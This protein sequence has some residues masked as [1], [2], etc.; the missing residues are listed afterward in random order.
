MF[1]SFCSRE[2]GKEILQKTFSL[3]GHTS[4]QYKIQAE[5]SSG[6]CKEIACTEVRHSQVQTVV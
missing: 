4:L 1:E 3:G 2:R 5:Y 6:N